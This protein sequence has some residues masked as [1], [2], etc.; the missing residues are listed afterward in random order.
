MSRN[1][2]LVQ[3][4]GGVVSLAENPPLWWSFYLQTSTESGDPEL[5]LKVDRDADDMFWGRY[6]IHT[7]TNIARRYLVRELQR[8]RFVFYNNKDGAG[9]GNVL[10][11]VAFPGKGDQYK[12][13]RVG[14]VP[15]DKN[16]H[17]L[18][19][20]TLYAMHPLLDSA[21]RSVLP[22]LEIKDKQLI[23]L[24]VVPVVGGVNLT[25]ELSEEVVLYLA[26]QQVAG[27]HQVSLP[28]VRDAMLNMYCY[29]DTNLS[30]TWLLSHTQA[31]VY[32]EG[33]LSLT[34]DGFASV[35]ASPGD[36]EK[37]K[38][39][40]LVMKVYSKELWCVTQTIAYIAGLAELIR[41]VREANA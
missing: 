11:L 13:Y 5:H 16:N 27:G 33:L 6:L 9:F 24:S 22:F 14:L 3:D 4:F 34:L 40:S 2:Q 8:R 41:L 32:G 17:A 18:V 38:G 15:D 23:L 26:K 37:R 7:T 35:Y 36:V 10:R 39:D 29:L 25:C 31:Y 12:K 20:A 21:Q 1:E 30:R 28:S 19:L